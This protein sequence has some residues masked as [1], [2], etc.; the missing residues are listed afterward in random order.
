MR[1]MRL[2]NAATFALGA[3]LLF[4]SAC[5][6]KV[7]PLSG[8]TSI[9]EGVEVVGVTEAETL[10]SEITQHKV[11]NQCNSA[12]SFEAQIQF[13]D[14]SSQGNQRILVLKAGAGGEADVPAVAKVKLE[15]AIEQH[16]ASSISTG[17]GHQEAVT[18]EVPPHTQ[19][20]YTIVWRETRRTGA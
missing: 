5:G 1:P 16:F 9:P 8:V 11:F 20:E 3:L 15:G 18:I 19:Q 2:P 14:S 10:S 6:P 7:N 4:V 13:S 17:E 12:S